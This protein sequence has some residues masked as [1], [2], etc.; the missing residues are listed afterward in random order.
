MVHAQGSNCS[1]SNSQLPVKTF[2]VF[3]VIRLSNVLIQAVPI[4]PR[5]TP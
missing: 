4:E 5:Q 1:N 2:L 3:S